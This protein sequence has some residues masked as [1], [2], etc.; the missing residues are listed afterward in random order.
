MWE[1]DV[2]HDHDRN[3]ASLENLN[4]WTA[5]AHSIGD[6][7]ALMP[8]SATVTDRGAPERVIGAEVS[9]GYLHLL[10]VAPVL[11]RD[12]EANDACPLPSTR[13]ASAGSRARL[14]VP[15]GERRR[16][17]GW[18]AACWMVAARNIRN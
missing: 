12:F 16:E 4:A 7:A 11:G 1:R 5:R 10:G 9:P 17:R 6:W 2:V 13:R 3:V 18:G 15:H 8:V 14:V